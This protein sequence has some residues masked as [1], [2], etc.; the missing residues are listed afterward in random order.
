M[1]H[2]HR[3]A[4]A[5]CLLS[6]S[7]TSAATL[8]NVP[9]TGTQAFVSSPL[10]LSNGVDSNSA[11][12]VNL[13]VSNLLGGNSGGVFGTNNNTTHLSGVSGYTTVAASDQGF[14]AFASNGTW[15]GSAPSFAPNATGAGGSG[16]NLLSRFIRSYMLPATAPT[17]S[18]TQYLSF[19]LTP[20]SGYALNLTDFKIDLAA[21]GGTTPSTYAA[22]PNRAGSFNFGWNLRS[23][24]DGYASNIGTTLQIASQLGTNSLIDT[25]FYKH[26]LLLTAPS[27]QNIGSAVT[28]RLYPYVVSTTL[29]SNGSFP[30]AAAP[31]QL[32]GAYTGVARFDNLE[33]NGAIVAIPEPLTA[34]V[35]VTLAGVCLL[36]RGSEGLGH[37]PN[38]LVTTLAVSRT[39]K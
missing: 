25:P 3:I 1:Q 10:T 18:S 6:A 32:P 13:A 17:S 29:F 37:A 16:S 22:A 15:S 39:E 27:F 21:S 20:A 35:L 4:L 33:L 5:I 2:S 38:D 14:S 28:F 26:T 23:S 34:S 19:T 31:T 9:F 8:L 36:R 12:N 7:S 24:L 30:S 11:S